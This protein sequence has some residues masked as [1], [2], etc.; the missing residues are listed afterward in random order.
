MSESEQIYRPNSEPGPGLGGDPIHR[1]QAAEEPL[2]DDFGVD[3]VKKVSEHL[4]E[5]WKSEGRSAHGEHKVDTKWVRNDAD[6]NPLSI[7]RTVTLRES[8]QDLGKAYESAT[9]EQERQHAE[10]MATEI[11]TARLQFNYQNDPAL[12]AQID[13]ALGQQQQPDNTGANHP[14]QEP[15]PAEQQQPDLAKDW[16]ATPPAIKAALEQQVAQIQ[17][18][19]KAFADSTQKVFDGLLSGIVS[20]HPA[21]ANMSPEGRNGYFSALQQQNPAEH[22]RVELEVKQATAAYEQGQRIRAEQQQRQQQQSRQQW[23]QYQ[24]AEDAKFLEKH[25]EYSDAKSRAQIADAVIQTAEAAGISRDNLLKSYE[26]KLSFDTRSSAVQEILLKAALYDQAKAN[27]ANPSPK[28]VPPVQRPGVGQAQAY[29]GDD[30]NIAMLT[31][32][33][34]KTGSLRDAQAL[35][36]AKMRQAKG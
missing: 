36:L 30:E 24:K 12:K 15:T 35:R 18:A 11:D 9:A 28:P 4:Q 23:D 34:T 13:E 21:I 27:I 3:D 7:D 31:R 5:K 6:G 17:A 33:L 16:A 22:A 14:I 26:G 20:R 10:A 29:S 19:E 2:S 25:P 32:R 8:A 1:P